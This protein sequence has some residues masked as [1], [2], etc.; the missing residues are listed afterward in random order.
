VYLGAPYAFI[1]KVFLIIKKKSY[2]EG[3]TPQGFQ[4]KVKEIESNIPEVQLQ[5]AKQLVS[6]L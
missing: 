4:Q 1:N 2:S 3:Q 6:K 5:A